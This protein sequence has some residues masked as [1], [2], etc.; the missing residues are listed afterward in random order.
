MTC[1]NRNILKNSDFKKG[2]APWTGDNLRWVRNPLDADDHVIFMNKKKGSG[3]PVLKQTVSGPF[4]NKCVYNLNFRLFNLSESGATTLFATVIYQDRNKK[5]IRSTPLWMNP[6]KSKK[7]AWFSYLTI[8][9]PPPRNAVY[10]SVSFLLIKGTVL[11]DYIRL[12]S[13]ALEEAPS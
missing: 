4:E 7:D 2:I 11:V 3:Y 8:V 5:I 9:P 6:P 10:T 12:T 1:S 13:R